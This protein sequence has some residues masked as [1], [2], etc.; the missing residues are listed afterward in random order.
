M[1]SERPRALFFGTPEI[2]VA[3]L[4]A[5]VGV[6]DVPLVI[7][8][9]DKPVGREQR[10]EPPPVKRRAVEL[11]LSVHQP[12]K[13]RV[14]E[15]AALLREQRADV[16]VVFAYGRILTAEVLRAPRLGC[17]NLHASLL[18]KY[19]GAAPINWAIARG[20]VETGVCL[21][22]MDEGLDTGPVLTRRAVPIGPDETA[23]ELSRRLAALG[24]EMVRD[25]LP[26]LLRGE[27]S[28]TP[29]DDA[30]ATFAP[31]LTRAHGRVDWSRPAKE[32]HDLV[33]AMTPWPGAHTSLRDRTLKLQTTRV[34]AGDGPPGTVL[35]A[36]KGGVFVACGAGAVE[37]VTA[38]LEGR[39]ALAGRE[40]AAGRALAV[41]D[42]LGAPA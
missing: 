3:A 15:F 1:T 9:P 18:P 21:M 6:C 24:A 7:C 28:P 8:Q 36:D 30:H 39:K 5:L 23:P 19:R 4:E 42:V 33:R 11:G 26:R 34:T 22:Q 31:I 35:R 38:Q 32:V 25:E 16:A 10:V 17:V 12:V 14:P 41:G 13:V 29:Q 20:E 40:L 2:A 37:L 27:L